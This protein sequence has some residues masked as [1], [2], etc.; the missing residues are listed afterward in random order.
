MGENTGDQQVKYVICCVE[1]HDYLFH[2]KLYI[3]RLRAGVARHMGGTPYEFRCLQPEIPGLEGWWNKIVLFD[4]QQFEPGTRVL[5][6]DLDTV[7]VGPLAPLLAQPGILHLADWGWKVNDYGSGVMVW[8]AGT[9]TDIYTSYGPGV[10]KDFRGDQDW[11]THL[12]RTQGPH[13]DWP[14]LPPALCKSYRYHSRAAPPA[15]C[16][17]VCFHGTPKPH[18]INHGWVKEQ[19]V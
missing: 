14:A 13:N 18:E 7:V 19:W 15:G 5:Y 1:W 8:D 12:A 6:L 4:P 3:E 2:G 9:H 10:P 17:V 11:I 16:S